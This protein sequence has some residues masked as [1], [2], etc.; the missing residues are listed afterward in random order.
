[1]RIKRVFA[2]GFALGILAGCSANTLDINLGSEIGVDADGHFKEELTYSIGDGQTVTF[3]TDGSFEQYGYEY[4]YG[5]NDLDNDGVTNEGEVLT[6]G[7]KGT[8]TCDADTRTITAA[9]STVFDTSVTNVWYAPKSSSDL[10]AVTGNLIA[11]DHILYANFIAASSF[12]SSAVTKAMSF[13]FPVINVAS[14]TNNVWTSFS[15]DVY[16]DGSYETTSTLLTIDVASSN[17]TYESL[18]SKY[19]NDVR[20][21][22]E[23]TVATFIVTAITPE[24]TAWKN[25]AILTCSLQGYLQSRSFDGANWS[26]WSTPSYLGMI[27]GGMH[28]GDFVLINPSQSP[29]RIY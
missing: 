8:Y 17:V 23:E 2:F 28:Y 13:S 19:S 12:K 29:M 25:G 21:S 27:M 6:A 4:E 1:M 7:A 22:A 14:T 20:F 15:K 10:S 3:K 5:S 16:G 9:F 11:F 24:D 26:S 18:N